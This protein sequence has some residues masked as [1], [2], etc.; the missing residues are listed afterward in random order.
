MGDKQPVCASP[1]CA[2]PIVFAVV[3]SQRGK[4]SRMPL[5]PDPN[6][7][8]NVACFRDGGGRLVGRVLAKDQQPVAYEKRYMPHFATCKAPAEHRRRKPGKW[9]AGQQPRQGSGQRRRPA[10]NPQPELFTP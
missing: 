7:E 5:D 4:P 8:G 10:P 2:Q 6:P 3:A 9:T 1:Q